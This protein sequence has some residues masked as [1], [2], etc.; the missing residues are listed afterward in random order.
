L[1]EC[2]QE[3]ALRTTT[4]SVANRCLRSRKNQVTPM[5]ISKSKAFL[6]LNPRRAKWGH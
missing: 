1:L 4:N 5:L 2:L 6:T 3:D